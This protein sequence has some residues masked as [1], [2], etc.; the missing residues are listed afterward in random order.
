VDV[1]AGTSR[2]SAIAR[3]LVVVAVAF[4]LVV[5]V[6]RQ[7]T[8]ALLVEEQTYLLLIL[9]VLL[10][11][12]MGQVVFWEEAITLMPLIPTALL[13]VAELEI[14]LALVL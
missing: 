12:A 1:V 11:V 14:V 3:R 2:R 13:Q 6:D 4:H 9:V 7:S 5:K 8:A 10:Q